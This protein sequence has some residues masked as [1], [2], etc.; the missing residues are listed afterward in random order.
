[1]PRSVFWW[2]FG[3]DTALSVALILVFGA[4]RLLVPVLAGSL[5]V[6]TPIVLVILAATYLLVRRMASLAGNIDPIAWYATGIALGYLFVFVV[7]DALTPDSFW[8]FFVGM[9][10][11][12]RVWGMLMSPYVAAFVVSSCVYLVGRGRSDAKP[13]SARQGQVT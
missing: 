5:A 12:P 3:V 10:E 1:M 11:D 6:R 4:D 8:F 7:L 13:S 9:H 2:F